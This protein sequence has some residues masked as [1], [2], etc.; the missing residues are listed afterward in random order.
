MS[1]RKPTPQSELGFMPKGTDLWPY[2]ENMRVLKGETPTAVLGV[3]AMV[4]RREDGGLIVKTLSE[5]NA[6]NPAIHIDG[7]YATATG[8][9]FTVECGLDGAA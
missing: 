8:P 2:L 9:G 5:V 1:P 6:E 3:D 7:K 4:S